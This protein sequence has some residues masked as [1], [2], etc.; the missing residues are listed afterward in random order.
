MPPPRIACLKPFWATDSKSAKFQF[1][2]VAIINGTNCISQSINQ[3]F[4]KVVSGLP[5]H[6]LSG[7]RLKLHQLQSSG[8][9]HLLM[10]Q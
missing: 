3:L 6:K 4:Y 9:G 2:P 8:S 7:K 5:P 10:E 1:V